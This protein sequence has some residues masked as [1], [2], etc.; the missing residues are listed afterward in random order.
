[1]ECPICWMEK[2][3]PEE[4]Q[5]IINYGRCWTCIDAEPDEQFVEYEEDY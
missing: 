5:H 1:M 2:D 3:D 4:I